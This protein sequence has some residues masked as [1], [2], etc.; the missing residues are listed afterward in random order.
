MRE[1]SEVE[2]PATTGAVASTRSSEGDPGD[3]VRS[4]HADLADMTEPSGSGTIEERLVRVE[5]KTDLLRKDL[6]EFKA[7]TR[8]G[9]DA[10]RSDMRQM[11]VRLCTRQDEAVTELRSEFRDTTNSL[12]E[13]I[14][15]TADDLRKEIQGTADDLRKEIQGTADDLRKEIHGTADDLRKEIHGTADDLR[16]EIHGTAGRPP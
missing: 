11:E 5:T 12:R 16:K 7:E 3:T 9:F 4:T 6:D 1:I 13:E 2:S 14:Q 15:G 8:S 10:V